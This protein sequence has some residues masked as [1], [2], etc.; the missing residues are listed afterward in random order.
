MFME[1]YLLGSVHKLGHGHELLLTF[2]AA[3]VIR[4]LIRLGFGD[5]S[6]DYPMPSYMR[7]P[8]LSLS[9]SDYPFY[10]VFMALAALLVFFFL[11]LLLARTR[12]GLIVRAAVYQPD[13]VGLLGHN[14]PLVHLLVFAVGTGL[15]GIAGAIAGAYFVTS[16][17]MAAD[18]GL[19]VFVVIVIGGL[20][21]L[22]GALVGS[23]L[24]GLVTSFSAGLNVSLLNLLQALGVAIQA[25]DAPAILKIEMSQLSAATP[26]ILMLVVLLVRPEGLFGKGK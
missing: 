18:L 19:M 5:L 4:E 13:M 11:Y 2:G 25:S 1:R 8:I 9:G 20:G 15:A 21:S 14:V 17:N 3:L 26:F 6:V 7:F 10:R 23:L 12:M 22:G 24:V 16:P